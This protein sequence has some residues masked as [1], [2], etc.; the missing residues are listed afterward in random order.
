MS[1]TFCIVIPA[2][3][4]AFHSINNALWITSEVEVGRGEIR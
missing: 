2:N 1:G 3:E 4:V